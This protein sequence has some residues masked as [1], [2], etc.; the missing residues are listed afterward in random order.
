MT[1]AN[2]G[3]RILPTAGLFA[4]F[5]ASGILAAPGDK[6]VMTTETRKPATAEVT[7]PVQANP[8]AP[9]AEDARHFVEAAEN[10]LLPLWIAAQRSSWVQETFIKPDTEEIDAGAA[11]A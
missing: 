11:Q 10:R 5:V 7:A 1:F 3:R 4:I 8:A 9:T 6:K 2:S